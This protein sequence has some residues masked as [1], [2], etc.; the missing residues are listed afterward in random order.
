M[1]ALFKT[2]L[3]LYPL[4]HVDV[5]EAL[6]S[7]YFLL[8]H[9]NPH[10]P[11]THTHTH[12]H[13]GKENKNKRFSKRGKKAAESKSS[14]PFLIK[15]DMYDVFCNK[16]AERERGRVRGRERNLSHMTQQASGLLLPIIFR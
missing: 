12:T 11:N 7:S 9:T 6:A 13:P 2:I 4:S 8:P 5:P 10:A 15:P 3:A 14:Y 1:N 16:A